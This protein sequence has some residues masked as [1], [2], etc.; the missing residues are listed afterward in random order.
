MTSDDFRKLALC[1]KTFELKKKSHC[2]LEKN[3]KN[4]DPFTALRQ[5]IYLVSLIRQ[6]VYSRI[7][8]VWDLVLFPPLLFFLNAA[9]FGPF[10][11]RKEALIDLIDVAKSINKLFNT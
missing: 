10:I 2:G 6:L 4:S 3:K 9:I 8:Y 7:I 11:C 1:K 5:N